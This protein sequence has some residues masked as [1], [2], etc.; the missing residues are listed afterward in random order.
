MPRFVSKPWGGEEIFAETEDYVG[1]I[2]TVRAGEVLSLQYHETKDETMRVLQGECHLHLGEIGAAR[3]ES[4]EADLEVLV[5]A[6]GDIC[7]I[8]PR[9]IHRLA[10][11]TDTIMLEVS[12]PHL[13]DVVRL[14]D[15]YGREGTSAA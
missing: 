12:T 10:A 9:T 7:R 5:L 2:L 13:D 14:E 3:K 1:K 15:E 4:T 11:L 8:P 6:P